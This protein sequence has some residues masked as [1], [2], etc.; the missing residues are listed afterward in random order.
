MNEDDALTIDTLNQLDD[1][2]DDDPLDEDPG[3]ELGTDVDPEFG[4]A[5]PDVQLSADEDR[6]EP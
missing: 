1:V 4:D 3:S 6:I 5:A 2:L